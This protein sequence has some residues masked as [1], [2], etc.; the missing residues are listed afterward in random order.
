M[1]RPPAAN[2]SWGGRLVSCA[3]RMLQRS[4]RIVRGNVSRFPRSR[5]CKSSPQ[6]RIPKLRHP[7]PRTQPGCTQR[8]KLFCWRGDEVWPYHPSSIPSSSSAVTHTLSSS[9]SLSSLVCVSHIVSKEALLPSASSRKIHTFLLC[10]FGCTRGEVRPL[11]RV[12][13][14]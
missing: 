14:Q 13:T 2:T 7:R 10:V 3:P 9:A 12:T 1:L 8:T 6:R 4:S 11:D 5:A